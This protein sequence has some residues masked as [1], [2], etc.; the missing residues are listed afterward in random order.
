MNART[1]TFLI[2]IVLAG[3]SLTPGCGA[4]QHAGFQNAFLPPPAH[5]GSDLDLG[6]PPTVE[7][8]VYIKDMPGFLTEGPQ[9][10]LRPTRGDQVVDEAERHFAAGK[11]AYAIGKFADARVEFDHYD[12]VPQLQAEKIIAAAKAAKTGEEE[13][14]E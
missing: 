5:H 13:E 11:Q 1:Q 7:P 10:P 4:N 6:H 9:M 12:Y 14:E 2:L 8:N 3:A